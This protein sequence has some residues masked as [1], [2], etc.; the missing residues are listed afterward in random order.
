MNL[1]ARA[2]DSCNCNGKVAVNWEWF[3]IY[4]LSDVMLFC[5]VTLHL[6][7]QELIATF[8]V[9]YFNK[10]RYYIRI[11]NGYVKIVVAVLDETDN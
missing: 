1:N 4:L 3:F 10:I 7:T 8:D 5:N 11:S 9:E 2:S 6:L